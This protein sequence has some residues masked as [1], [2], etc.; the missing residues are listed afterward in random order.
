LALLDLEQTNVTP[1]AEILTN[2]ALEH[3]TKPEYWIVSTYHGPDLE[4]IYKDLRAKGA[5]VV[6]IL[7]FSV[8]LRTGEGDISLSPEIREHVIIV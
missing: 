7:P 4:D 6:W 8:G 3:K 5:R 2:V 1:F